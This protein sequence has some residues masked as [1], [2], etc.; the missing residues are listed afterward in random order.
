MRANVLERFSS[1]GSSYES[2]RSIAS[3]QEPKRRI[4]SHDNLD[5]VESSCYRTPLQGNDSIDE[6]VSSIMTMADRMKPERVMEDKIVFVA[7]C[8][9]Q[10]KG[11]LVDTNDRRFA[12]RNPNHFEP[13]E[14]GIV[15][16]KR[17]HSVNIILNPVCQVSRTSTT[18]T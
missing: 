17:R 12:N 8:C 16:R 11:E 2:P 15:V 10:M 9:L 18:F 14:R 3:F 1:G 5:S 6:S 4:G 13:M 7:N